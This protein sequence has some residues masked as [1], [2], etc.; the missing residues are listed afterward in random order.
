MRTDDEKQKLKELGISKELRQ[1]AKRYGKH[2]V[3]S[4]EQTWK[5]A[6]SLAAPKSLEGGVTNLLG[7]IVPKE[8]ELQS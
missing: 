3:Y 4:I 2:D 5:K 8:G 6:K 1:Y 7:T